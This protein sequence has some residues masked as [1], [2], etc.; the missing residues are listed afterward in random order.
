MRISEKS[1]KNLAAGERQQ[2]A[3]IK[4]KF[5]RQLL[6]KD[7]EWN[8]RGSATYQVFIGKQNLYR[9]AVRQGH[10]CYQDTAVPGSHL[11]QHKPRTVWDFRKREIA[12]CVALSPP[13]HALQA[14]IGFLRGFRFTSSD[15]VPDHFSKVISSW[16]QQNPAPCTRDASF[17]PKKGLAADAVFAWF[18]IG[19]MFRVI[20]LRLYLR[21][22]WSRLSHMLLTRSASGVC[23]RQAEH[24]R[25]HPDDFSHLVPI[26]I[27]RWV[28]GCKRQSRGFT[29]DCK[30]TPI[31]SQSNAVQ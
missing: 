25:N 12:L 21:K 3:V 7:R 26:A 27:A 20:K 28:N 1:R 29:C 24:Y 31:K 14:G 16:Q 9:P 19:L 4:K 10:F 11:R 23:E 2:R 13:D 30:Q 17:L 18:R 15:D 5:R 22:R 8:K 6:T